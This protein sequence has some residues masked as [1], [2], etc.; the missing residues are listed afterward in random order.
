MNAR[1]LIFAGGS[2]SSLRAGPEVVGIS[3]LIVTFYHQS[4]FALA[5]D[6]LQTLV[7]IHSLNIPKGY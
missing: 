3:S 2:W 4:R 6:L 5:T 1:N 7:K